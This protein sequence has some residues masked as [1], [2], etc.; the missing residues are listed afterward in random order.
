M[1]QVRYE[2]DFWKALELIFKTNVKEGIVARTLKSYETARAIDYKP[3]EVNLFAP[4]R[5]AK[6]TDEQKEPES[7]PAEEAKVEAS[8]DAPAEEIK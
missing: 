7:K 3:Y 2:A 8:V 4:L 6:S 1:A 5:V